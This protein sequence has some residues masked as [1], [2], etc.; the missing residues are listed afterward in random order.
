MDGSKWLPYQHV[1][2]VTPP[3]PEYVSGHSTFSSAG[4]QI[5]Q[6]FTRH[7]TPSART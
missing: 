3:F 5:L 7:A 6:T 2:V 4:A 1:T